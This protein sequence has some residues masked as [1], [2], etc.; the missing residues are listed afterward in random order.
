MKQKQTLEE[1]LNNLHFYVPNRAMVF[2]YVNGQLEVV[3]YT[4][5]ELV[6]FHKRGYTVTKRHE[7]MK[8]SHIKKE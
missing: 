2:E 6:S 7:K 4:K 3:S 8:I 5:D 1:F